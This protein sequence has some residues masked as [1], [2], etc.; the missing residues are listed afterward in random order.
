MRFLNITLQQIVLLFKK[1]ES[2]IPV[3]VDGSYIASGKR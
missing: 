1:H 3:A 2:F